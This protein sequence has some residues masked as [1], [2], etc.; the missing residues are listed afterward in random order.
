M[1]TYGSKAN[2]DEILFLTYSKTSISRLGI[3]TAQVLHLTFEEARKLQKDIKMAFF[4]EV[5]RSLPK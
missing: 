5:A 1:K 3:K 4:L 2:F